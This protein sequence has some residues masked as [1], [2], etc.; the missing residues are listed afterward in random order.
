MQR[1]SP[2]TRWR[3]SRPRAA[4]TAPPSSGP[5]GAGRPLRP[6][7]QTRGSSRKHRYLPGTM[8]GAWRSSGPRSGRSANRGVFCARGGY[9]ATRLLG[10]CARARARGA[11]TAGGLL[12]HHGAAAVAR[13]P[14]PHQRAR[15]G[16]D[17]A[18][19]PAQR[20]PRAPLRAARV[21]AARG[22][23]EARRPTSAGVVEGRLVGGNLSVLSRV[24]GTR[25]CRAG[26]RGAAAGGSASARTG[27][28]RMWTHLE[29][30]GVFAQRPR[31]R[32]RH[33]HA[34]RGAGCAHTSADVLRELAQSTGLPCAAGFPIGHGAHN[35]PV[36][37]GVRV[38]LDANARRLTFLGGGGRPRR[39]TGAIRRR[40]PSPRG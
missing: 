15:P 9:G 3:S 21:G 14:G 19:A 16:A 32:A 1:S 13:R 39:A 40:P 12:R 27:L 17:A 35:E 31:H 5:G 26:G 37:L 28:D 33:L 36:P 34:V 30:A 23:L 29:L 11:Q 7:V 4:S 6:R 38:R 20:D 18:R 24:L 10:G 2:G 22:G 25:G 8:R